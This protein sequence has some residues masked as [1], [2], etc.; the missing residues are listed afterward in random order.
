MRNVQE[1][2]GKWE[3][4]DML[5]VHIQLKVEVTVPEGDP[6]LIDAF[7]RRRY[8]C[9]FITSVIP[10]REFPAIPGQIPRLQTVLIQAQDCT[11]LD[12]AEEYRRIVNALPDMG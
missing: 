10:G 9:C 5:F 1:K 7:S 8:G 11:P 4:T 3:S 2:V 6:L 12:A